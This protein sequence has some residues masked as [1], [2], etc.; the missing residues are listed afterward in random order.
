MKM[1]TTNIR[2]FKLHTPEPPRPSTDG[3]GGERDAAAIIT[4]TGDT[5]VTDIVYIQVLEAPAPDPSNYEAFRVVVPQPMTKTLGWPL[6]LLTESGASVVGGI[7]S[8]VMDAS[9]VD[10]PPPPPLPR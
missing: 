9:T 2:S 8:H 6:S 7:L 4:T 5:A 1:A 10:M 3:D